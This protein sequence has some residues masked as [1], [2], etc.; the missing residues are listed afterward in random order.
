MKFLALSSSFCLVF[1]SLVFAQI[2]DAQSLLEE[3]Y[4]RY[5]GKFN[6]NITFIQINTYYKEDGTT[7]ITTSFEAFHYPGN[8]RLDIGPEINQDGQIVRNDTT[9]EFKA[10]KLTKKYAQGYD[11]LLLTGDIFF[12]PPAASL[13]K[14]KDMGFNVLEFREDKWKNEPVYVI[15][16]KKDDLT[17][18]QFWIDKDDLYLVRII[19]PTKE[20]VLDEQFLEHELV[21]KA[22][23]ES[24]VQIFLNGKKIRKERYTEVKADNYIHKDLFDP[25]K[26][27]TVHW[28]K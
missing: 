21:G 13:K 7:T 16:A 14:L 18:A 2:K 5:H 22:W 1:Y 23:V 11:I 17:T 26:W 27:G 19:H 10:G 24:E 9:Y 3:Q 8:Y 25:S 15:G 28:K 12:L 6:S 4:K 20:G